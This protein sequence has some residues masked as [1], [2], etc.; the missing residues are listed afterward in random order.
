MCRLC[1]ESSCCVPSI[2]EATRKLHLQNLQGSFTNIY[3]VLL[4][5]YIDRRNIRI[6]SQFHKAIGTELNDSVIGSRPTK[7]EVFQLCAP[8]D[9][10]SSVG[11]CC[12]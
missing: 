12:L 3:A 1:L 4:N 8:W 5:L 10:I 9:G 6:H 11:C 2:R 7:E